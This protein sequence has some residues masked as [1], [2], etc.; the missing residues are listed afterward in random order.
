MGHWNSK[1]HLPCDIWIRRAACL[2]PQMISIILELPHWI[3]FLTTEK[4][5]LLLIWLWNGNP[6]W[7]N[8]LTCCERGWVSSLFYCLTLLRERGTHYSLWVVL[9][10][11]PWNKSQFAFLFWW[12]TEIKRK[13]WK[14][15]KT[16]KVCFPPSCRPVM[17]YHNCYWYHWCFAFLYYCRSVIVHSIHT[18]LL[19][20]LL[21]GIL[22]KSALLTS[23]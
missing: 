14:H 13:Q 3:L 11:L 7:G 8:A 2:C 16:S 21:Q 23:F 6:R 15:F 22:K 1:R 19:D 9:L 20:P 4:S 10:K 17:R 18:I 5:K 12:I